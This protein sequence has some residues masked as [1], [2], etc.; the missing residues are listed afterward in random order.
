[1]GIEL[2]TN[3]NALMK[4]VGNDVDKASKEIAIAKLKYL[5]EAFIKDA[6]NESVGNYG[7]RTGN[8][9]S[10]VGYIVAFNGEIVVEDFK[11][12]KGKGEKGVEKGKQL[13]FDLAKENSEGYVLICLAGM[14]YAIY[15]ELQDYNVI[16]GSEVA[17]RRLWKK[18]FT[19]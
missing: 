5:G 12:Y 3:I 15:V 6:R 14:E 4:R 16:S 7:D 17:V 11:K 18:V 19:K 1:M 8:L 13:A 2:K 9:R 10:S